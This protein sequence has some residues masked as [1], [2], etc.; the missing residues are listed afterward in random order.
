MRK[1]KDWF[2]LLHPIKFPEANWV[3]RK[4]AGM[5]DEEC[6]P[7]FVCTDGKECIS[8]W[9][10]PLRTRLSILLHGKVWLCVASGITQPPVWL[11]GEKT[12]FY[13]RKEAER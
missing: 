9:K 4:P 6:S 5:T 11:S 3:L 1:K 13:E 2:S 8:C 7:L 10:A 12:V